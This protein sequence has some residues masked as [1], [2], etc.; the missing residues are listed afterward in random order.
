MR[1]IDV[2]KYSNF[3]KFFISKKKQTKI[4]NI[5]A[6]FF[7]FNCIGIV[8]ILHEILISKLLLLLKSAAVW[9]SKR[10]NPRPQFCLCL[11]CSGYPSNDDDDDKL[12]LKS[13]LACFP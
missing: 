11:A 9:G 5:N 3:L 13:H 8:K 1:N 6:F 7:V 2:N 10:I 12:L 4:V